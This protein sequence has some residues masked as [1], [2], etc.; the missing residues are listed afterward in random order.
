M[1]AIVSLFGVIQIIAP[2]Q[3]LPSISLSAKSAWPLNALQSTANFLIYDK[4]GVNV[5][6]YTRM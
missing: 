5:M 2:K 6:S 4:Q 1:T 3:I